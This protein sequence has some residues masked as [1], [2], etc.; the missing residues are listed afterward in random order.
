MRGVIQSFDDAAGT[1]SILGDDGQTYSFD[2]DALAAPFEIA[3]GLRADFSPSDGAATQIL[4]MP[5]AAPTAATTPNPAAS[6]WGT[7]E[8]AP[9]P[10][11]S[12]AA[13][14]WGTAPTM[15]PAP[16]PWATKT[17]ASVP[18]AGDPAGAPHWASLFTSFNGRI[19]RSHF[20]IGVALLAI[21]FVAAN[22]LPFIGFFVVLALIWPNL[23]IGVKR[24]HDMGMTGWINAVPLAVN[25]AGGF[26]G[27]AMLGM[28]LMAEG[29]DPE[30]FDNS[31]PEAIMEFLTPETVG[32]AM[33]V[34]GI[35]FLINL[36]FLA[37]IGAVDSQKG[38]NRY[39]PNPKG[40]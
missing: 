40:E 30:T 39:G 19:R 9:T 35:V 13:S 33:M 4:L 21:I 17:P 5:P 2:R 24:L 28:A 6:P 16:S 7:A 14:P 18:Q 23:A 37:W 22:F 32:P 12:A 29:F 20:W 8:P 38:D 34:L 10:A 25:I 15:A 36:A 27:F 1:G 3:T 31:D 26:V 11:T